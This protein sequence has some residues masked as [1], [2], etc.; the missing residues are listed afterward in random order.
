MW[1]GKCESRRGLFAVRQH[2]SNAPSITKTETCRSANLLQMTRGLMCKLRP[3][4]RG[5]GGPA[6]S[7]G[8]DLSLQPLP[9]Q[10]SR[11]VTV[12]GNPCNSAAM[13]PEEAAPAL[14]GLVAMSGAVLMDGEAVPP[15]LQVKSQRLVLSVQLPTLSREI[16]RLSLHATGSR[17]FAIERP[18]EEYRA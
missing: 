10:W 15:W 12:D 16:A 7:L 1:R 4:G 11:P 18:M 14:R 9:L 6:G 17:A 3:H 2:R 8:T 13:G 5:C